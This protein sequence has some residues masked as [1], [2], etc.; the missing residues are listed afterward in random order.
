MTIT[1]R[2]ESSSQRNFQYSKKGSRQQD[3][4]TVECQTAASCLGEEGGGM[5]GGVIV[6]NLLRLHMPWKKSMI[7]PSHGH[8]QDTKVLTHSPQRLH[9]YIREVATIPLRATW[10]WP[11]TG[12][13]LPKARISQKKG[14]AY[15]MSNQLRTAVQIKF[16]GHHPC[17]SRLDWW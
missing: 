5:G 11:Q 12:T 13:Q 3:N 14:C 9:K 15:G 1:K 6:S 16:P 17:H 10:S 7:W 4:A 2:Q 8:R